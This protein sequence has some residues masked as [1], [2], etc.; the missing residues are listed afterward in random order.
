MLPTA[1]NGPQTTNNDQKQFFVNPTHSNTLG[2]PALGNEKAWGV[3]H[4]IDE[5]SS[6]CA[7]QKQV[8]ETRVVGIV[9]MGAF[10]RMA[11]EKMY[12]TTRHISKS[13]MFATMQ[14]PNYGS[15]PSGH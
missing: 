12:P 2:I 7:S 4:I 6:T 14:S 3:A 8:I 13:Y 10:G 1:A 5:L 15:K 9:H 11:L